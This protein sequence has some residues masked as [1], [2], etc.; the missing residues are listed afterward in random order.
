MSPPLFFSS[1][2]IPLDAMDLAVKKTHPSTL[3]NP[4]LVSARPNKKLHAGSVVYIPWAGVL[5]IG[6]IA[7]LTNQAVIFRAWVVRLRVGQLQGNRPVYIAIL[8]D[9]AYIGL[10]THLLWTET[11]EEMDEETTPPPPLT[12][13]PTVLYRSPNVVLD[14]SRSTMPEIQNLVICVSSLAVKVTAKVPADEPSP[15]IS[16]I[17][18]LLMLL[19]FIADTAWLTTDEIARRGDLPK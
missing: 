3:T 13:S 7:S 1:V 15:E 10:V 6:A 9:W 2:E 8:R 16:K 14:I 18:E 12:R 4:W 17:A 11:V 19:E 5:R